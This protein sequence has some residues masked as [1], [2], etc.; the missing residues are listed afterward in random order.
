MAGL[1]RRHA[2]T[3]ARTI[4]VDDKWKSDFRGYLFRLPPYY[5][6]AIR[7][8]LRPMLPPNVSTLL[9]FDSNEPLPMLCYSPKCLLAIQNGERAARDGNEWLRCMEN[10]IHRTRSAQ[11]P[12]LGPNHLQPMER[13]SS[14]LSDVELTFGYGQYDPRRMTEHQYLTSLRNLPPP[15]K[16]Q[17]EELRSKSIPDPIALLPSNSLLAYYES[18]RRWIFGGTGLLLLNFSSW[19]TVPAVP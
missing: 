8:S 6:P 17:E 19:F 11:E 15:K 5:L 18:R 14:H 9:N 3:A 10:R 4:G 2:A 7:R 13:D 1:I 16:G 12:Q